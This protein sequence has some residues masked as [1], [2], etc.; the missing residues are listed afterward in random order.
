MRERLATPSRRAAREPHDAAPGA[1][2]RRARR[3]DGADARAPARADRRRRAGNV[4]GP[5]ADRQLVA[6]DD[7]PRAPGTP[8]AAASDHLRPRD[9]PRAHRRR[10][11]PPRPPARPDGARAACAPRS[12]APATTCIA[13]RI[14]YADPSLDG[15]DRRRPRPA[16]HHRRNRA[17]PP[18][19][20]DLRRPQAHRRPPRAPRRR[21]DRRRARGSPRDTA[22]TGPLRDQ[23]VHA[24]QQNAD[25]LRAALQARAGDRARQLT[26]TLAN[27]AEQEQQHV[28]ATLTELEATIRREAFGE[29]GDQLQLITGLELDAGD[30]RQVERD[31]KALADPARRDPRR[32]SPPSRA[33]I[34]RRYAEPTHRLFPAAV[35][36][37]VPQGARL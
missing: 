13:S 6:R 12:G 29:Q 30:R 26:T 2:A 22:I 3:R 25:Q 37:L 34:A 35:T 4:G 17:P 36:L 7:R 5:G 20:A 28:A 15:L 16:G 27:R 19:A 11:R 31:V 23:L 18:R 14:R 8:G 1:R 32:R 21:G 10:A 24:L 9:R 33:A